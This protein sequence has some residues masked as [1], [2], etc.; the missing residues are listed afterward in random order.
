MRYYGYYS[1]V[2][3]GKRMKGKSEEEKLDIIEIDPPPVSKELKMG[4]W[5]ESQAP[6]ERN[7]GNK[8]ITFD[9]SYSQVI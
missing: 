5:E 2:S 7:Q 6:P 8:E 1:N 9:P 3:R 4:L